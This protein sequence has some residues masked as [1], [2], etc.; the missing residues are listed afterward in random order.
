MLIETA[1]VGAGANL[2]GSVFNSRSQNKANKYNAAMNRAA[3]DE[4][5]RQFD[6]NFNHA[7]SARVADAKRAGLHP[8]FALGGGVGASGGSFAPI[9]QSGSSLGDGISAAGA[10]ASAALSRKGQ[11]ALQAAHLALQE[12]EVNSRVAKNEAEALLAASQAKRLEQ[13][14][15]STGTDLQTL[16]GVSVPFGPPTAELRPKVTAVPRK[17]PK[18][19]VRLEKQT[20]PHDVM[21]MQVPMR[22]PNGDVVMMWNPEGGFDE[23]TA[24]NFWKSSMGLPEGLLEFLGVGKHGYRRFRPSPQNR[25]AG[26]AWERNRRKYRRRQSQTR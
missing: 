10:A 24:P 16:S 17:K 21:P 25:S 23:V 19:P 11:R 26:E 22:A 5:K 9:P 13:E 2:L 6:Q 18:P 7:I 20:R 8:L 15:L 3:L 1:L 12:K 14:A 4:T